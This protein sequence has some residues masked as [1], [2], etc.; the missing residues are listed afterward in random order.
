MIISKH[1]VVALYTDVIG[2]KNF[3]DALIELK[4]LRPVVAPSPLASERAKA[5]LEGI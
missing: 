3:D 4:G 2:F 1:T 5:Y